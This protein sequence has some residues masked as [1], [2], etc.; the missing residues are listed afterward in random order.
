MRFRT[1]HILVLL[2]VLAFLFA[3]CDEAAGPSKLLKDRPQITDLAVSPSSVR[4]TPDDGIKDTVV[5][6]Q[7][8]VSGNLPEDYRLVAD[9]ATVRDRI[10]LNSDTLQSAADGSG[11]YSGSLGIDMNT[12]RFENL[13]LY[14]FPLGPDGSV[15]DRLES[16]ISVRGIDTG[17][18]EV[19]EIMHPDAVIIPLPGEPDNRFFIAAKVSHTISIQ[20][21]NQVRLELFDG[22]DE[23]IFA[24][25]MSDA[26]SD[27]GNTPGDSIYVQ[28][29]SIN[30]DNTPQNYTVEVH[31]VD[32]A[33]TISDTLRSTLIISR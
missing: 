6:F 9:I 15:S 4:F 32:I 18:P 13:V 16:T 30:P 29:F 23:R 10:V 17:R 22:S 24:S 2:P 7:V 31:A 27:Y 3:S 11:R 8:A 33:G 21:I 19:L 25:S 26:N 5:T 14:V 28:N 12:N 20:N 1:R